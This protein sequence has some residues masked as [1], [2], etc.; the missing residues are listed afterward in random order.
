MKVF[1]FTRK[2][3]I[4]GRDTFRKL[5]RTSKEPGVQKIFDGIA[6]DE[7]ALAQKMAD[8]QERAGAGSNRD[9]RV[10][11]RLSGQLQVLTAQ[12]AAAQ[13]VDDVAAFDLAARYEEG[14]CRLLGEAAER[15]PDAETRGLLQS[16]EAVEC[17]EARE[18]RNAHDFVN[19]P[20]EFLAWGEFSNFEEFGNFGREEV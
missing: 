10:L 15:E 7:E 16:I 9:S 8:L 20:N 1:D 18:L 12:T 14:V 4:S 11:A 6:R 2:M 5:A 13:V 3:E 17:R 19:A